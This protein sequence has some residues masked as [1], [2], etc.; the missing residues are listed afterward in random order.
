MPI[1]FLHIRHSD[2]VDEDLEGASFDT[3][4]EATS[5][6]A[7]ALRELVAQNLRAARQIDIYG[8]EITDPTGAVVASVS[9]EDAVLRELYQKDR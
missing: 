2:S 3:L 1:Y 7:G 6:A 8:I 4:D 9:V 5:N